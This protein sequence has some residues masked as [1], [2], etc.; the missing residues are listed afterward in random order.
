MKTLQ[1]KSEIKRLEEWFRKTDHY[2]NKVVRGE[3]TET[4]PR[5]IDYKKEAR[6]NALRL[7]ELKGI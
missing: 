2:P 5:W 6:K 4:T 1:I 3:W 7:K